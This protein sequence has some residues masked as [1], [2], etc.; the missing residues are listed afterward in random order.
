MGKVTYLK[1]FA[2][3]NCESLLER[4]ESH[5]LAM[6]RGRSVKGYVGDVRRFAEWF[7]VRH[8]NVL[9]ATPLDIADYRAYLQQAGKKPS[10]VNRALVSLRVFFE[11]AEKEKLVPDNPAESIRP[12]A[13][14]DPGPKWLTRQEQAALMRAV[15]DEGS[16]RDEAIIGLLLHTGIRVGE[17]VKLKRSDIEISERAGK[18]TVREGK[19]NKY[20]EVPLNKTARKILSRWLEENP[21]GV[22]FPNRYGDPISERAVHMLVS[23]YAYRAKI[24][25][26]PHT[27]RHT[28]CKNLVDAGVSLDRV[29]AIAGHSK[30]ETTR[31]YTAPSFM[32]LQEAA[33]R[34]SWE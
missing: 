11:W 17:L 18:I 22:L 15:R 29:A 26:S 21:E 28:F 5:L 34:V 31:R 16:A 19:G 4:F 27:L 25:A 20:R 13:A 6:D 33:E 8:G 12:V 32:D 7:S 24:R 23:E 2:S 14:V 10:T 30:L 1:K 3:D 9:A